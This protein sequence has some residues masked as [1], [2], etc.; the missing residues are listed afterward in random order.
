M[1]LIDFINANSFINLFTIT[2]K[3]G[4]YLIVNGQFSIT[5]QFGCDLKVLVA[6]NSWAITLGQRG[7]KLTTS[8]LAMSTVAVPR[9]S[10]SR[11][12]AITRKE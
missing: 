1:I 7:T 6:L 11:T 8:E 9:S 3:E 10:S 4:E 2:E 12:Q 5:I